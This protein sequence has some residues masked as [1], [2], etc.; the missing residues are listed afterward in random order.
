MGY[1]P[2]MLMYGFQP[3]SLVTM[4]LANEH[5]Q[6]VK[7]FLSDHMDMLQLARQNIR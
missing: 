4:G 5:I 6:F 7:A 2:F 3:I 1:N